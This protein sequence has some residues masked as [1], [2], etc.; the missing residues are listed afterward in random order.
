MKLLIK[1]VDTAYE[2]IRYDG[3]HQNGRE[4]ISWTRELLTGFSVVT[5]Q[6]EPFFSE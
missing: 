5:G 4:L 1:A 6:G 3:D 2:K